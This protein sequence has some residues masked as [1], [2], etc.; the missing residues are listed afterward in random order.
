M[1]TSSLRIRSTFVTSLLAVLAPIASA[2]PN[3]GQLPTGGTVAAG[4]AAIAQQGNQ[5]TVSQGSQSAILNWQSFNVGA[6][7]AV[8]FN[9]P[10]SSAVALNRVGGQAPSSIYGSL[11]ANG[12]VFLVNPNGVLFAPGAQV[13]VGG[14]VASSLDISDQNFLNSNYLF[15]RNGATG[16]VINAGELSAEYVS[17]LAPEVLNEGVITARMVALAGSDTVSLRLSGNRLVDITVD[18][19]SID[20][21]IENRQLVKAD[22]G[23]VIMSAQS[24]NGLR[25]QLINTGAI[26]A[27]GIVS[28]G[29][30]I[31]LVASDS[32]ALG[33]SISADAGAN[34][35]G[36]SIIAIAD[37]DNPASRTELTGAMSARGGSESGN[38]GFIETSASHIDVADSASVNTLAA[39]GQTGTWLLDPYDFTVAAVDG[40]IT[41]SALSAALAISGVEIQTT[42]TAAS[43][44][45]ATCEAGDSLGNGDIFINDAVAWNNATTLYLNAWR[46]IYV[47]APIDVNH[48]SGGLELAVGQSVDSGNIFEEGF[49]YINAPVSLPS[50]GSFG[51]SNFNDIPAVAYTVINDAAELAAI[52]GDLTGRYVLGN[53]ITA[54]VS[55][56]TPLGTSGTPFEGVFDGLLHTIDG[57]THTNLGSDTNVGLFGY[58]NVFG[59]PGQIQ[60]VGLTNVNIA[61][62]QNV[63]ALVGYNN[64]SI[65]NSYATGT[66]TG[67]G[68][69]DVGGIG[70]LVGFSPGT[71]SQSYADVNVIATSGT[72]S[73][74]PYNDGQGGIGGLVGYAGSV[75]SDSY[76]LGDVVGLNYVGGLVGYTGAAVNSNFA[77]GAVSGTTNV[78]GLVGGTEYS[79]PSAFISDSYFDQTV[80]PA[81]FGGGTAEDG[82]TGVSTANLQTAATFAA[83]NPAI[84]ELQDGAYPR[85]KTGL[86]PI[87][88]YADDVSGTYTGAAFTAFTSSISYDNSFYTGSLNYTTSPDNPAINAGVYGVLPGGLSATDSSYRF[89]Y[90]PGTL[91]INPAPLTPVTTSLQG[92][93]AKYYDGTDVATLDSSNFLLTGFLNDDGA[94]VTETVGTFASIN[95]NADPGVAQSVSVTLDLSD[96]AATGSTDL[97][98][99]SLTTGTIQGDIGYILPRPLTLSGGTFTVDGRTYDGTTAATVSGATTP[100]FNGSGCATD[101]QACALDNGNLGIDVSGVAAVYD[102][103]DVL[104]TNNVTLT[105]FALT[106]SAAGNYTVAGTSVV[107]DGSGSIAPKDVSLTGWGVTPREYDGTTD[108]DLTG[109]T[110]FPAVSLHDSGCGTAGDGMGC[111]GDTIT[112]ATPDPEAVMASYNDKDVLD[113]TTVTITGVALGG[114]D[115]G[116][117]NLLPVTASASI[118]P[119]EI[120]VALLDDPGVISRVYDGT[121]TA[122]AT[123]LLALMNGDGTSWGFV[124]GELALSTFSLAYDGADVGTTSMTASYDGW[125]ANNAST[126]LSNYNLPTEQTFEGIAEI[127]PLAISV[128]G[129]TGVDR[130][131]NATTAVGVSGGTLS[132]VLPG[133]IG[134]VSAGTGSGTA[135][136]ANVDQG[137]AVTVSAT[138]L[139]G[140][141]AA[142]YFVNQFADGATVNITPAPLTLELADY[143]RV[144]N[145]TANT[146]LDGT[147][148][149]LFSADTGLVTVTPG[150]ALVSGSDVVNSDSHQSYYTGIVGESTLNPVIGGS[151]AANYE[152]V[153]LN[154]LDTFETRFTP[155]TISLQAHPVS[156]QYNGSTFLDIPPGL[157]QL[158]AVAAGQGSD[159]DLRPI[160]G[161]NLQYGFY[162]SANRLP[163]GQF[164]TSRSG[165]YGIAAS[166]NVGTHAVQLFDTQLFPHEHEDEYANYTPQFAPVEV[167][168]TPAP[169][170]IRAN[171]LS[172][173]IG[174]FSGFSGTEFSVVGGQLFASDSIS[175]VALSSEGAASGAAPGIYAINASNAQG[176]GLANYDI[177]YLG[178]T[179]K[180]RQASLEDAVG[181]LVQ[182][183]R[184]MMDNGQITM[185]TVDSFAKEQPF[186][187]KLFSTYVLA[188]VLGRFSSTDEVFEAV[189]TVL[190]QE[191]RKPDSE[192]AEIFRGVVPNRFMLALHAQH[193]QKS[194][195][196]CDLSAVSSWFEASMNTGQAFSTDLSD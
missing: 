71:I 2:Q 174:G 85:L 150:T 120:A 123:D 46:N 12:Q 91:T 164:D 69:G 113:A 178:G 63:G 18:Q 186:M 93:V 176:T 53:D 55:S 191:L 183:L 19:A 184:T 40:D 135:A 163:T 68:V 126:L 70:G 138:S 189:S 161:D 47:N 195:S 129:Q 116:N 79:S 119:K 28:D 82:I 162:P 44:A 131:Y 139:T 192:R 73:G 59:G 127:R 148:V 100:T 35:D 128:S 87:F 187:A 114:D 49:Y 37:L 108:V 175:S 7:A 190:V 86:I 182:S 58:V 45:N 11:N 152:L 74:N 154:G 112:F 62:S 88:V 151:A 34:G 15:N 146:V 170:H 105:G 166:A 125:V 115:A 32:I 84:W 99:Y 25:G 130:S 83:W 3:P 65:Y 95:A 66:L 76:A 78:G 137:I 8:T 16:A 39:N 98:N 52:S 29:G 6:D 101:G 122:N 132:G 103:K 17:L 4:Q 121:T 140:S 193:I 13:D 159:D 42:D 94:T 181:A 155:K 27:N 22:D 145:G 180:I 109:L 169:L 133:D 177:S 144:Y 118:L 67:S 43:C 185:E 38:G 26:E 33:G 147:L 72:Q 9:Q 168:I 23:Q 143:T 5:M 60:N 134:L 75:V 21:L 153:E 89:E 30:V 179:L 97:G 50:G 156:R 64:G 24:A 172:A 165:A 92:F 48:A 80:N 56:W 10:N 1:R 111:A 167:T 158:A 141:K 106:G 157:M 110:G 173:L 61:G 36:G 14:L 77:A 90:V 102:S 142:N 188:G 171:S 57:L 196:A 194:C 149:G 96:Y 107:I 117:Y 31:R 54:P 160:E 124:E 81:L 41:G 104:G 51:V 136:S 20:T